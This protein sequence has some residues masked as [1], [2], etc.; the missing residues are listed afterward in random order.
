MGQQ[1]VKRAS[2]GWLSYHPLHTGGSAPY[3]KA[4]YCLCENNGEGAC[5]AQRREGGGTG[6]AGTTATAL[7]PRLLHLRQVENL[8]IAYAEDLLYKNNLV[9]V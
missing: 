7:N 6:T 4:C 3:S 5:C 8:I 1:L 9:G 2:M